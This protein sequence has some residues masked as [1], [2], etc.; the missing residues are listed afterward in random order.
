L[1]VAFAAAPVCG[2]VS[3]ALI[4]AAENEI[5]K[6]CFEPGNRSTQSESTQACSAGGAPGKST[7]KN[8]GTGQSRETAAEGHHH[9]VGARR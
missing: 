4:T 6:R 3:G 2:E 1:L 8:T 9:E 7:S 5:I